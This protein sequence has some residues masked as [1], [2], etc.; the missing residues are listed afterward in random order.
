MTTNLLAV[1][2]EM[3]VAEREPSLLQLVVSRIV[4]V[5]RLGVCGCRHLGR[6]RPRQLPRVCACMCVGAWVRACVTNGPTRIANDM[7]AWID[8]RAKDEI[9]RPR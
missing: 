1:D 7:V 8:G 2:D 9:A 4:E 5:H 3:V 6:K